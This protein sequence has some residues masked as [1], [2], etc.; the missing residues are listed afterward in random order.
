MPSKDKLH[1]H[2]SGKGRDKFIHE[3]YDNPIYFLFRK[4]ILKENVEVHFSKS[5]LQKICL[6]SAILCYVAKRGFGKVNLS[7]RE[8]IHQLLVTENQNN[9]RCC[10]LDHSGCQGVWRSTN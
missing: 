3:F 9:F 1:G 7:E 6:L 10:T 4:A 5:E 8:Y 2:H